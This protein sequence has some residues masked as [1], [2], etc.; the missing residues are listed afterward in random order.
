MERLVKLTEKKFQLWNWN[1]L[2]YCWVSSKA[3]EV[4]RVI[5]IRNYA[6]PGDHHRLVVVWSSQILTIAVKF[7][8]SITSPGDLF[9]LKFRKFSIF[10]CPPHQ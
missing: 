5:D 9:P 2:R 6:V 4:Q 1:D 8:I 10:I 7:Q 3:Y